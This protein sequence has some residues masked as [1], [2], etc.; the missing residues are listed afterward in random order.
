MKSYKRQAKNVTWEENNC[1][2]GN[3]CVTIDQQVYFRAADGLLMP[4]RKDQPP[5]DLRYFNQGRK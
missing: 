1:V 5:P 2:E 4:S 3:T